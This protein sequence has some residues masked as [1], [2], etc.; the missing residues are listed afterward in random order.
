MTTSDQF[1]VRPVLWNGFQEDFHHYVPRDQG[2]AEWS[3]VPW[4]P[5]LSLL[6]DRRDFHGHT[7]L[8]PMDFFIFCLFKCSLTW[9]SCT[10]AEPY[11]LHTL[12]GL[13]I[14][15]LDRD[16][17]QVGIN[18]FSFFC[19]L[20]HEIP[21]PIQQQTNIFHSHLFA[22]DKLLVTFHFSLHISWQIC[23]HVSSAFLTMSQYVQADCLY[24]FLDIF[25]LFHLLYTYFLLLSFVT[26][27]LLIFLL[28]FVFIGFNCSGV[29]KTWF[30]KVNKF[31]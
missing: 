30:L 2:E 23:F 16:R 24:S 21:C 26:I 22:A 29:W 12:L 10:E 25:L 3:V 20:Y 1:L 15:A 6:K 31:L 14:A 28:H 17:C 8:G 4:I 11:T 7:L 27:F 9:S 19:V 13:L 5:L 18:Y